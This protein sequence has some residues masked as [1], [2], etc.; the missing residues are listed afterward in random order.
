VSGSVQHILYARGTV[1]ERVA[2]MLEAKLRRLTVFNDG[3][4]SLDITDKDL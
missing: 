2:E 4:S 1:E 3:L